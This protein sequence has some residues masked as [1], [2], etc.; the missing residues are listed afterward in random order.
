MKLLKENFGNLIM[1]LGEILVGILLLINPIGFT[2]GIIII[3]GIILTILGVINIINYIR[4]EPIQAM[5]E[6]SLVKGL[7]FSIVGLYCVFHSEWFIVTF[8]VITLLYGIVILFMG[9]KKVQWTFDLLRIKSGK[10]FVAGISALLSI[11]FSIIIICNP[12][13][14][15]AVL[16]QFTG[17]TLIIEAIFDI[18]AIILNKK[19]DDT[20]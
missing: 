15:T 1:F 5:Y 2:S 7:V 20:F 9:L 10:W 11:A 6:Q 18:V 16:W 12:F 17:I 14:T 13:G 4:T 3:A 19:E 8:P